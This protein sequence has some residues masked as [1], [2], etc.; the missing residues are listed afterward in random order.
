[1][2][3]S[4]FSQK[5]PAALAPGLA[6]ALLSIAVTGTDKNYTALFLAAGALALVG[7]LITV[8]GVRESTSR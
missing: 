3:I 4:S 6:P 8:I 7:G 1:M 5:I 2:A